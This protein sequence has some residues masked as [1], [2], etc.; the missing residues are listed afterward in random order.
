MKE[1]ELPKGQIIA[2]SLEQR[3]N[4]IPF[5]IPNNMDK[6]LKEQRDL[7][8]IIQFAAQFGYNLKVESLGSLKCLACNKLKQ[9]IKLNCSHELCKD[10]IYNLI[11]NTSNGTFSQSIFQAKCPFCATTLDTKI[12]IDTFTYPQI[13]IWNE[14]A[15]NKIHKTTFEC[16]ICCEQF[17]I[18]E[19]KS[20]NCGHKFNKQCIKQYLDNKILE[21]KIDSTDL[22]CPMGCKGE[23]ELP[24]IES[25]L[26]PE[27]FDKLTF[28]MLKS[29]D[30]EGVAGERVKFCPKDNIPMFIPPD[31][32]VFQ[33]T[34]CNTQICPKCDREPHPGETCEQYWSKV[35][36][37]ADADAMQ[38]IRDNQF[39]Q[40][41]N[42]RMYIEKSRGCD[43]MVCRSPICKGK[44]EFCYKCGYGPWSTH[45]KCPM[46]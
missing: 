14:D 23:I 30:R 5:L 22:I 35:A 43:H 34:V 8:N 17:D 42:C 7:I 41:P 38:L 31:A 33:C 24:T 29:L 19:V 2:N 27:I 15:T 18:N 20:L 44:Y 45:N 21:I 4:S 39:K 25:V 26:S 13:Q 6:F 12:I 9:N 32:E 37:K 10:C 3:F 1:T 40:C 16:P 36:V 11:K 46:N 28:L